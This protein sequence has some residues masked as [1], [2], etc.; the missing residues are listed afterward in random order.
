MG[1]MLKAEGLH[2][3]VIPYP[4]DDHRLGAAAVFSHVR[5]IPVRFQ[6][7]VVYIL[8]N[9]DDLCIAGDRRKD[10]ETQAATA[11]Q[12]QRTRGV[13]ASDLHERIALAGDNL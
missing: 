5:R 13:S 4:I 6:S 2:D 1:G 7:R 8:L 12:V 10:L 3:A 11:L 9:Q